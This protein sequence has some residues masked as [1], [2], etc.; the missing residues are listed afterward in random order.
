MR[1]HMS[2]AKIQNIMKM[3]SAVIPLSDHK[4][5]C[6]MKTK[7]ISRVTCVYVWGAPI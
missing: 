5:E 7:Y 6:K 1:N 2:E 4:W 3:T